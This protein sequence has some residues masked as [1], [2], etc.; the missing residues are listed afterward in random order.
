MTCPD[1]GMI[2]SLSCLLLK[3]FEVIQLGGGGFPCGTQ[4]RHKDGK[5]R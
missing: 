4:K 5:K 1:D 3:I 2:H